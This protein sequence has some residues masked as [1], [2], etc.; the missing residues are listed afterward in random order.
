MLLFGTR[1]ARVYPRHTGYAETGD[2]C[3]LSACQLQFSQKIQAHRSH[4][5]NHDRVSYPHRFSIS[6]YI[7]TCCFL[8]SRRTRSNLLLWKLWAHH[9]YPKTTW[10][11]ADWQY[12]PTKPDLR[13]WNVIQI[14]HIFVNSTVSVLAIM[15]KLLHQKSKTDLQ[16]SPYQKLL[17]PFDTLPWRECGHAK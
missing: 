8:D 4:S 11:W 14:M 2:A 15:L 17:L 6:S 13:S 3:C 10:D 5:K 1:N 9:A 16:C 7:S 12:L